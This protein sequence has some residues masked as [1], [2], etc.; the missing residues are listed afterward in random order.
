MVWSQLAEDQYILRF[1]KG[2]ELVRLTTEFCQEQSIQSAWIS[3]LGGAL[4]AELAFYHLDR[5]AYEFERVDEPLELTNITGNVSLVN[6]KP[7]VHIHATVGD[8]NYHSYSG[9]LKELAVAATAEMYITV[10]PKAINRVHNDLCG[11]K[12]L[13]L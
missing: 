11:L 7:F 1:D 9:H 4:W 3:G 5:K 2:D 10:L 12:I 6:D 13:D 8:M